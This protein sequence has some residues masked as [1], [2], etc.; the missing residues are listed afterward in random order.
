MQKASLK[1]HRRK[2]ISNRDCL[3]AA[4]F[5]GLGDRATTLAALSFFSNGKST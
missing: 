4:G 2:F 5:L 3:E 1:I